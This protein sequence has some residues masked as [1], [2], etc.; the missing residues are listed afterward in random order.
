MVFVHPPRNEKYTN[1]TEQ[2][3]VTYKELC[4][5]RKLPKYTP[6]EKFVQVCYFLIFGIPKIILLLAFMMVGPVIF[7]LLCFIWRALGRP[8]KFKIFIQKYYS[9]IARI[10]LFILGY[11]KVNYHGAIDPDA[12]FCV[13]NHVTFL[14]GWFW[15]PFASRPLAKKE[16]FNWPIL[17]DMLQIY[18]GIAVDRSKNSGV[19]TKLIENALDSTMPPVTMAP[20]GATTSGEY[21][22]KFH[23]G[24]FLSDLPVQP[25]A[26]RYTVYGTTKRFAHLSFFHHNLWHLLIFLGLPSIKVDI[27]FMDSMSLKTDGQEDSRKFAD[28]AQLRI[29]NF[30]GV[31]AIDQTNKALFN[32]EEKAKME[33]NNQ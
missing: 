33:K 5:L 25:C 24:A 14:D 21:M 18:N 13:L 8:N 11:H 26:I 1:Q 23:L 10:L 29:A 16:L 3:H 30:L 2:T 17:G 15:I 20:E 6:F 28:A 12:R 22:F 9:V 7:M 4:E 19:T 32:E 27:T 31:M